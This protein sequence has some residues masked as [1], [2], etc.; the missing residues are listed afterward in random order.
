MVQFIQRREDPSA[1]M[2][3][4]VAD[5]IK[6]AYEGKRQASMNAQM[7]QERQAFKDKFG[8]DLSSNPDLAKIQMSE[9][10]KGQRQQQ[11]L[12]SILQMMGAESGE[13]EQPG[14]SL[15]RES[16]EFGEEP[17][18]SRRRMPSDKAVLGASVINPQAG[19]ILESMRKEGLKDI[20]HKE[21][22][23]QRK[24]EILRKETVD[25]R[26]EY[27]DK[28]KGAI[29][30]IKNKRNM[31]SMIE[32]GN[33]DDP[34]VAA[35]LDLIPG[36]LG[37]RFL[38]PETVQYKAALIDEFKDLRNIF[39]GQTRVK[40]LDLLEQKLADIYLTDAQKKAIISSRIDALKSDVVKGEVAAELEDELDEKGKFLGLS[41]FQNEVEKRSKKKMDDI[42]DN[43]LDQ[44]EAII[45]NAES[46][47]R[48]PLS[49]EDPDDV[50]IID[51]ILLEAKGDVKKAEKIAKDRGYSW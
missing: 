29:E 2:G 10:L 36:N 13:M 14:S 8:T 34:S 4:Q 18:A 40:E 48:T 42:F 5:I 9:A 6:S 15:E 38:S 50:E 46:R 31:L 30:G 17:R 11:N 47:K 44:Q 32:S 3:E 51:Q 45:K 27:N 35:V 33:L 37:K 19:R 28:A 26:K 41:Q 39:K 21:D 43:V 20:R 16:M 24:S 25:L 7:A 22:I 23:G 49:L 1:R 12:A